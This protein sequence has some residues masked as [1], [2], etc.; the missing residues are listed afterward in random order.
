MRTYLD[1][2]AD[3]HVKFELPPLPWE[4]FRGEVFQFRQRFLIEELIELQSAWLNRDPVSYLDALVDIDYVGLGTL[5]LLG[6][7]D[8]GVFN[9]EDAQ[10]AEASGLPDPLVFIG[11]VSLLASTLSRFFIVVQTDRH[12]ILAQDHLR[13]LHLHVAVHA[14][15]CGFNF[16]EAWRRVHEA[17]MGKVRARRAQD[18]TRGSVFDVVK[19][20]GWVAPDLSDLVRA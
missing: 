5:Y 4:G 12:P 13:A 2:I 11:N 1:D 3:F 8:N 18:S 16:R 9:Q 7:S 19:P 17:N 6:G 14:L 20:P 15:G 10:P